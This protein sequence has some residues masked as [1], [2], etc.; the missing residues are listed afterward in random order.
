MSIAAELATTQWGLFTTAQ[1]RSA[2]MHPKHIADLIDAGAVHRI[3]H[4]VHRING[5]PW[6]PHEDLRAAWLALDPALSV[7]ERLAHQPISCAVSHRSAA[8]LLQ[9]GDIDADLLEFTIPRR[10]QSR[11]PD[12]RFHTGILDVGDTELVDGLPV[13]T[14]ARIIDDL[15]GGL[16][17]G[18]H[19]A[20][21]IRDA[22]ATSRITEENAAQILDRHSRRYGHPRRNGRRLLEHLL[23]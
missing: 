22:L 6:H 1:A 7:G 3:R 21:I 13:T 16:L 4:G 18:G 10:R 2:G 8:R 9:L 12:Q 23:A 15:A 17:D 14:A 19:L 5:A 11:L 20:G